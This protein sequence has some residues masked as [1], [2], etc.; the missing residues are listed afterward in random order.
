MII[1][2]FSMWSTTSE[3]LT[4]L[5]KKLEEKRGAILSKNLILKEALQLLK[6]RESV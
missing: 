4:E 5:K 1:V 3:E 2:S 6:E